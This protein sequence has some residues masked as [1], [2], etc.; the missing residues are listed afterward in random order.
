MKSSRTMFGALKSSA[1]TVAWVIVV[2]LVFV[3]WWACTSSEDDEN[4]PERKG[5]IP[6][7][8]DTTGLEPAPC[9]YRC[10]EECLLNPGCTMDFRI[11][12]DCETWAEA[13]CLGATCALRDFEMVRECDDC[14]DCPG[15][16]ACATGD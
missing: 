10:S 15:A 9:Y 1:F 13:T 7:D 5:N 3:T 8:D 16:P 6:T 2:L 4:E 11:P 12:A 14:E